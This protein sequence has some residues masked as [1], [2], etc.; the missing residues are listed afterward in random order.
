VFALRECIPGKREG[1]GA[2]PCESADSRTYH[3]IGGADSR[4]T[5]ATE[6]VLD[7]LE[8]QAC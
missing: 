8:E 6:R 1:P 5:Y 4:T 2:R 7:G 3:Q